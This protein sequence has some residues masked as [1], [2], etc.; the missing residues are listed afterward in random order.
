MSTPVPAPAPAP[1]S[2]TTTVPWYGPKSQFWPHWIL[3]AIIK[4]FLSSI[5]NTLVG[6]CYCIARPIKTIRGLWYCLVH[7][8]STIAAV[9]KRMKASLQ[10]NG[11]FYTGTCL[12]CMFVLPGAGMFGKVAEL[13]EAGRKA[14][15][16]NGLA[17]PSNGN[18]LP[19]SGD[20]SAP[21]E[22]RA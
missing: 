9:G 19:A 21:A 16:M 11:I 4:A 5:V 10:R 3:W 8:C 15:R 20:V 6:L 13:S 22:N 7:P 2:S 12:V 1:V 14:E 17:L 18:A